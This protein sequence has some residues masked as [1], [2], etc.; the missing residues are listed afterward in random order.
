MPETLNVSLRLQIHEEAQDA[1]QEEAGAEVETQLLRVCR[2]RLSRDEED[3]AQLEI[4]AGMRAWPV[5]TG[6]L[7]QI[8]TSQTP[9]LNMP[10]P[11]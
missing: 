7:Y 3:S 11:T 6:A 8:S 1:E 5:E 4:D 9:F 2:L 10:V